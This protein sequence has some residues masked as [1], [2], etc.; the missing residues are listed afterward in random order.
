MQR[1][2]KICV[3]LSPC[4]IILLAFAGPA[5]A[6]GAQPP[7]PAHLSFIELCLPSSYPLVRW[8]QVFVLHPGLFA[9]VS[10]FGLALWWNRR[11]PLE[12]NLVLA[13][14]TL[15]VIAGVIAAFDSITWQPHAIMLPSFVVG[16]ITLLATSAAIAYCL[17]RRYGEHTM[18][19]W[20][21]LTFILPLLALLGWYQWHW[22]FLRLF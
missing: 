6:D 16:I 8:I 10:G 18:G 14:A 15:N 3:N 13:A 5:H 12:A 1:F 7:L 11:Y 17:Y 9:L 2:R 20:P 22:G 19:T 21:L 4:L